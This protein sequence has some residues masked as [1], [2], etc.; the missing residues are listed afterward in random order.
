MIQSSLIFCFFFFHPLL[1]IIKLPQ[2]QIFFS[3]IEALSLQGN[4]W[5]YGIRNELMVASFDHIMN[6]RDESDIKK[7]QMSKQSIPPTLASL[8]TIKK[9][10]LAGDNNEFNH[11][12]SYFTLFLPNNNI[13]CNNILSVLLFVKPLKVISKFV[14]KIFSQ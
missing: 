11:F 4:L 10:P 13:N 6:A 7:K 14:V 8:L 9:K 12:V 1:E 2:R 5:I 3:E